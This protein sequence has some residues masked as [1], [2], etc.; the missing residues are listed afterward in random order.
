[1]DRKREIQVLN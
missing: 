1:M